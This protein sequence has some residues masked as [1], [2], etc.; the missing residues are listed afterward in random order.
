MNDKFD[1]L[2]RGLA[3]SVTRRDALQRFTVGIGSLLLAAL[4]LPRSAEAR[5][6][7]KPSGRRC[8]SNY[9]CCS[10]LCIRGE[11]PKATVCA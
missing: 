4:G 7:C 11:V 2:A 5:G 3:Q 1:E 10:G 6:N 8:Q 9:D